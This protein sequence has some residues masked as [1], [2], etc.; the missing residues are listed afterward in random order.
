MT[1][2]LLSAWSLRAAIALLCVSAGAVAG[3]ARTTVNPSTPRA[4]APT[5]PAAC[6]ATDRV[7]VHVLESAWTPTAGEVTLEAHPAGARLRFAEGSGA[8]LLGLR[9]GDVVRAVDGVVP[10]T[11]LEFDAALAPLLRGVSALEV[12]DLELI[13]GVC[14]V[15]LRIAV[16]A[17][18]VGA[19][20]ATHPN[21]PEPCPL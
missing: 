7:E 10:A 2:D 14:P 5:V 6:S 4:A 13:R 18:P 17:D 12:V 16:V 20:P 8:P 15:A 3:L 1:R 9:D 21:T 11:H 19:D